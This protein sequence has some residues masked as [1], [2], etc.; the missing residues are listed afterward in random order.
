MYVYLS[1]IVTFVDTPRVY[2]TNDN[3]FTH[4][5]FV[6]SVPHSLH[7]TNNEQRV[8]DEL[9]VTVF[10]CIRMCTRKTLKIT[11]IAEEI[12]NHSRAQPVLG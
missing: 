2:L 6:Q 8:P 3:S 11:T 5:I 12:T 7:L 1:N 4:V 10:T 9:F